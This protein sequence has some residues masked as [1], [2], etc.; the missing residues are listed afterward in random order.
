MPAI[1]QESGPTQYP[2]ETTQATARIQVVPTRLQ[3]IAEEPGYTRSL[4]HE[5]LANRSLADA[6]TKVR[7]DTASHVDKSED[8]VTR[9]SAQEVNTC[10]YWACSCGFYT[11]CAG[12]W[13]ISN[14][15]LHPQGRGS[16]APASVKHTLAAPKERFRQPQFQ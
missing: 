7:K 1:A 9:R 12:M 16:S 5:T 4:V 3:E 14:R 2:R 8:F 10:Q 6:A 11:I 15:G 13:E